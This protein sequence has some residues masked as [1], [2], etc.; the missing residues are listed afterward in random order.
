MFVRTSLNQK[1]DCHCKQFLS[2]TQSVMLNKSCKINFD[3]NNICKNCF[4]CI[5]NVQ[6]VEVSISSFE[7]LCTYT[8]HSGLLLQLKNVFRVVSDLVIDL[9]EESY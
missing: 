6:S 9:Y 8:F 3:S 4:S 2:R 1:S 7:N 5:A